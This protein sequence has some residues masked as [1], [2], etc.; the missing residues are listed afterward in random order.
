[1]D[2]LFTLGRGE[3]EMELCPVSH[4]HWLQ[5]GTVSHPFIKATAVRQKFK[6]QVRVWETTKILHDS[7]RS[8][9]SLR[10]TLLQAHYSSYPSYLHG[11]RHH[12]DYGQNLELVSNPKQLLL[13][14]S[15]EALGF[16]LRLSN[17]YKEFYSRFQKPLEALLSQ[18]KKPQQTQILVFTN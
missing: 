6:V 17:R 12:R 9:S 10:K 13:A 1:M 8:V 16:A 11:M 15:F 5:L 18:A 3:T 7:E 2:Q 14:G 4:P